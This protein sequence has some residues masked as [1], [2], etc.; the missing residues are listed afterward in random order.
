MNAKPQETV[1]VSKAVTTKIV[2]AAREQLTPGEYP[3]DVAVQVT[4]LL[5]VAE[6]TEKK[7]TSNVLTKA[8]L[9]LVLKYAGCTREQAM[10]VI[11]QAAAEVLVDWTGSDADKEIAAGARE[12]LIEDLGLDK[13]LAA[14]DEKIDA[15]PRVPV[16]GRCTFKG[17]THLL[18]PTT[19]E[20]DAEDILQATGTEG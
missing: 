5:K 16:K 4:G 8:F 12:Q 20:Q 19:T 14:V 2:K 18:L 6:D 17:N 9:A 1:A 3:V 11:E 15:L 13:A 10:A 7:P